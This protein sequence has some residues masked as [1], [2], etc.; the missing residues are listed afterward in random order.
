L[1]RRMDFSPHP[2]TRRLFSAN[3]E[4]NKERFQIKTTSSSF[5]LLV[6]RIS[7]CSPSHI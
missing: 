7:I 6:R 5:C 2:D 4:S 1:P 3:N